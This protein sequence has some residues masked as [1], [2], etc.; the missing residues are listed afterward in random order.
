[1]FRGLSSVLIGAGPSHALYF[2]TYE[3]FK[4]LFRK[5]DRSEHQHG[6]HAAAGV[7]ATTAHDAFATPFDVVK[8][9]MQISSSCCGGTP[10]ASVANGS[11]VIFNDGLIRTA[12]HILRTEGLKA[13][14]V[15][16]PTTLTMSIP[17]QCFQF[18][19]YE[20]TRKKLNPDGVYDPKSHIVAGATAGT[21]AACLTTPLDVAKTV[22]QTRGL[23]GTDSPLRH[24]SGL[25][26]ACG[27]IYRR[28][29]LIGFT[30]G[31]TARV[32][33][34][35]PATAICWTTVSPKNLY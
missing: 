15:S 2:S 27:V 29:G 33:S 9:R 10:C 35:A 7:L 28:R 17:Y 34:I 16:Y 5:Y 8:Q 18:I 24:V 32:I 30:S 21:V 20:Y 3:H 31:M 26:E 14:Y 6:A 11:R 13:F 19:T 25:F 23:V 22:L 12:T 4:T 1:M